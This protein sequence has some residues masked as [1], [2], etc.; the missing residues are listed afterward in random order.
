MARG[1]LVRDAL[2]TR[3]C[4]RSSAWR[5]RERDEERGKLG[6]SFGVDP[7]RSSSPRVRAAPDLVGT[8]SAFIARAR[9]V[10]SSVRDRSWTR[11][12]AR[13]DAAATLDGANAFS[14]GASDQS[15]LINVLWSR[16]KADESVSRGSETWPPRRRERRLCCMRQCCEVCENFMPEVARTSRKLVE[17]VLD[18]RTVTLCRG[19]ALIAENSGVKSF[20]ALRELYGS[21]RRSYVPRRSASTAGPGDQRLGRG[22]RAADAPR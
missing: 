19:H 7:L 10:A 3:P 9:A 21:G 14:H 17:V 12:C 22:R 1:L 11:G 8:K 20:E 16:R 5:C 15:D 18:R 2:T 13:I 6:K 4:A